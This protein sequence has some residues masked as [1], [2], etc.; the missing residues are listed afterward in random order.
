M[1]TQ[2]LWYL[3]RLSEGIKGLNLKRL[4]DFQQEFLRA[5]EEILAR[6]Q[7]QEEVMREMAI[8]CLGPRS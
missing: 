8:R 6:P 2:N 5:F 3:G 7:Q 1:F 4:I